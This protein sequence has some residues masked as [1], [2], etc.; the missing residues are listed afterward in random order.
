MLV[1]SGSDSCTILFGAN[2][3]LKKSTSLFVILSCRIELLEIALDHFTKLTLENAG[4][5]WNSG[6]FTCVNGV[7]ALFNTDFDE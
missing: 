5:L 6:C 7:N 1:L 4:F 3:V 2:T